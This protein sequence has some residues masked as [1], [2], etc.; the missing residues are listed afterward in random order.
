[1]LESNFQELWPEAGCD[2]AGRGCLAGPVFA[3]SLYFPQDFFHPEIQ[4][5]KKLKPLD[6]LRLRDIIEKN[7]L[8]FS[9]KKIDAPRID[10]INILQASMEAMHACIKE[11]KPAPAYILID[12]NYFPPYPGVPHSC[13]IK[14]DSRFLAIAA[15]SILAK[16]YRDEFMKTIHKEYPFYGWEKN[17]GYPTQDHRK[18]LLEHGFSPYHR[19]SFRVKEI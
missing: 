8:S 18:A 11:L 9:V 19:K 13:M 15:A 2:E 17:K 12:G 10:E 1:M 7:A 6:R 3:A 14:G 4:D 5:S 16:T